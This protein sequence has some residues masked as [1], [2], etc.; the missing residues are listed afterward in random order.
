MKFLKGL[1]PL[2]MVLL[3]LVLVGLIAGGFYAFRKL[4]PEKAKQTTITTKASVPPL[5]YDK[6]SNAPARPDPEFNEAADVQGPEMRGELM[7]WNAQM[8]LMYAVGGKTTSKGSI[9]Q[10]LRLNIHLDVQNNTGKQG[11]D[12][13][14]FAEVLSKGD[15]NPSKGATFIAWMGDGV[16]AYLSGLNARLKKDLGDE[17][18]AQVITFGGA[19]FG[20]DKWM[21]KKKYAKDARGSL[22]CTVLRDG[23]WNIAILKSQLMGWP[24][25]NDPRGFDPTKVNFV[26]A[27]NDD[28]IE[29]VKVYSSKK[30]ITLK[31]I[32]D[33]KLTDKDTT[34]A[35]TGVATWYPGDEIAVREGGG[36]VTVA[37]TAE[38]GTQMANAII[39][40]KKYAQDN[41][42]MIEKFVEMVGRGG[43]QVKSHGEALDFASKVSELVYADTEKKAEDY[44][45]A[46]KSYMVT[47]DDG[48]EVNIGGSR[49]FNL[50]DAAAYT[51]VKGGSDK[52]KN[53]YNTFGQIDIEA[54][55]D[56]MS[57]YPPYEEV[58][59]WSYLKAAFG[60]NKSTA[61]EVSK[62]DFKETSKGD[63]AGDASYAIQFETG[64]S[65][66]KPIS[67]SVLD[68]IASKLTVASNLYVEIHGYTDNTGDPASNQILS[69]SRAKS[70]LNYILSKDQDEFKDR[71]KSEGHGESHTFTNETAEGKSLN[72]RVEIK[73]YKA[74]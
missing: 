1:T 61:G 36:L 55:P 37:S 46:Y 74:N 12:L 38:Y 25:N 51:G 29:A 6:N 56:V 42:A 62:I 17:Y 50:A 23:D 70:V 19:S 9:A 28:Y 35:V 49:V 10:E 4:V 30:K 45:K 57:S 11:E 27:P 5:A 2:S 15:Q 65:Q 40:I 20:E 54:F 7:G 41:R 52:Y 59:D 67:Y 53:I 69:E 3:A 39:F 47:D 48:N 60:R 43:D 16:P 31:L 33:G 64:S 8:G 13:Y 63:K 24:V 26:A 68:G 34:L 66:I 71:L 21:L 32:K 14:A 72:R 44:A 18:V 22:T 73:L 58:T